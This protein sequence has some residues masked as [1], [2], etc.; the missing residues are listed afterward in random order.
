M[1]T[2]NVRKKS[3]RE[4]K[5]RKIIV[6]FR[7]TSFQLSLL[8]RTLLQSIFFCFS[9]YFACMVKKP[10]KI[11]SSFWTKFFW[12]LGIAVVSLMLAIW[13]TG[14]TYIYKTLIYTYPDI[15][16]IN[17]FDTRIVNDSNP[18]AWPYSYNYN[19]AKISQELENAIVHYQT[20]AFLVIKDDSI[21]YERY[22]DGY[23]DQSF[24]NSFS[25]AKSIIGVL[26]GIAIGDGLFSLDDSVGKFI[27]EFKE[28]ENGKLK[29]RHLLTMSSGVNWDESYSNLFSKTTEAYY[30]TNLRD[31]VTHLKVVEEPGKVFRYMSCNT[32]LLS[33]IISETSGMT[34]SDFASKKLWKQINT[35]Q[36]AYWSLDHFEGLEKAYCCFYSSARDFA[37]VGKLYM[38]TGRWKGRTIVPY[39]YV[40]Q[41]I[42][43]NGC[44][45]EKGKTIDYY[46]YQWWL[47]SVFDHKIFYARGIYGQ[48]IIC[49]P[50]ERIIIVRLGKKRGEK[51]GDNQ[52]TD[53]IAYT[54]GVLEVYGHHGPQK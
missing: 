52:Y 29:I 16:D 13:I 20:V 19:K 39:D 6:A 44:V 7:K 43:P 1:R 30:G 24:S 12:G 45:D 46:G 2:S 32:V 23:E 4:K 22:S 41:S 28:G 34:I 5:G 18:Q 25:V 53:M 17:I 36:P 10:L 26:T 49:I 47:T 15:D 50:D 33:L 31:L 27:P 21:A 9:L 40:M 37:K 11:K 48:Y 42:S 51:T 54:K 38:D 8:I 3:Q 35:T 14:Y